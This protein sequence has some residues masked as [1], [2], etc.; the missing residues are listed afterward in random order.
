M[1]KRTKFEDYKDAHENFVFERF[2]DGVL[3]MRAHTDG[4][5]LVWNAVSHDVMADAFADV[6]GD[7]EVQCVVL[8][9][10]GENFNADWGFLAVGA[11]DD[12]GEVEGAKVEAPPADWKPALEFMDDLGW[13]G[14]NMLTNLLDIQ[15]PVIAAVNGGC[16]MHAE[17]PLL[18][19]IVLVSEDA[20][21]QDQPH[22]PRGMVPGDG[23]HIAW[24]AVLGPIRAS[25]Y[26]LT[27]QS[28]D[29]QQALNYGMCN[30][31]LPRADLVDRA[32]YLAHEIAKKPPM[33]V[34][35][36]RTLFVESKRVAMTNALH[37]GIT[38]E[39]LAQRQYYPVGHG[40]QGIT[41]PW[42]NNPFND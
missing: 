12:S 30:E 33:A 18:C 40:Q 3:L 24:P 39:L 10:T 25:Y 31:I 16:N 36:T 29:A 37:H 28:I 34:R 27:G 4:G 8:T 20:W 14:H 17:V 1:P 23:T 38:T 15:V 6:S 21:F 41:G 5:P 19:D 32:L 22:F 9:G 13:S 35:Y 42:N 11:K 2:D 7:R 26:L